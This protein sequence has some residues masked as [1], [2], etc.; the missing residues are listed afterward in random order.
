MNRN[1]NY[2]TQIPDPL[3]SP[4]YMET[5]IERLTEIRDRLARQRQIA[6]Q[7]IAP[8]P[9]PT[10]WD[11]ISTELNSL[12]DTQR[13]I[14]FADEDYRSNDEAIAAIAAQY[15]MQVLMPYVLED[16]NGKKLLERQLHL[17]KARKDSI[18]RA[19][20]EEMQAFRTWKA[21]QMAAKTKTKEGK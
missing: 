7:D 10:V 13:S 14:L 2:P 20:Q 18:I 12:T 21:E 1:N 11:D 19:E 5:Q 9:T 4:E 16:E 8:E 6:H 15:Q 3:L 17:I